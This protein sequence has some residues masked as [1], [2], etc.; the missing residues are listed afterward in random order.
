MIR[1]R[2]PGCYAIPVDA[3]DLWAGLNN[4]RNSLFRALPADWTSVRL[5][6]AAFAPS[7]NYQQAG[8]VVYQDDNNYVQVTRNYN[9][10]NKA[11]FVSEANGSPTATS[12]SQGAASNLYFR[13][14]RDALTERITGYFSVDGVDWVALG[15]AVRTL[16]NPRL[17]IVAGAS[18]GGF[19]NADV[20]WAEIQSTQPVPTLAVTPTSLGFSAVEGSVPA[21]QTLALSNSGVGVMAWTATADPA[22]PAWLT[23]APGSGTGAAAL[24]VAADPTGLAP[25]TYTKAITV[26]APGATNTPRT[27]PVTLTVAAAPTQPTLALSPAVLSFVAVEGSVPAS[28]TLALSNSGVGVMAWTATADAAAPAW[29]A[30][31]P[32]SGTGAAALTVAA[33]PTGLAPGTYTKTIT[34][35]APGATNTPRTVPVTLVVSAA[36]TARFNFN[37]PDRASLLA[38]G[39][40]FLAATPAGGVRDTEQASGAVVSYD[41]AA[42]PGVL[43]IPVD[44]GDLWAGFNNTRNSLFRALPADWTSV[45][46]K[47]AAFAPSA[48]YQQAGLVVYQDDNN[49]VQVTRNYNGGNKAV[50][51]S[52]ANG[53]PTATSVSQGAASNLYFRLDRDALTERITGYFSVDGVNWVA[54]GN[55]VRTLQNPR[56]AIVAGA[57]AGGFPNADVEWAEIQSTQPVPTLAVTPTS[58]G[59]SAVEGSVPAS[60]TLALSNSG[61]G[62]MAWTATADPAAPAWLTVAPGSGTGAAALT[63]AA[64]PTGLAPGTYTKAITV[65]APGATNT[66]RTIPVTLTVAAAPTQPTLALSPAVLSFVAVEGSVPASQTL[67]LSNS[68]VGVMAWTA[69][70]DAA[71]PAW[72]AV[73]PGSGTGAA[74][75]TVAVDP[76][77]LAPGTYTKTITVSAPG[78]TNTPRTVPVTLVVSAAGT[79]RFNFNYPDRAS[80]LAGGWDFLAATPAGGVRD[81]EQASGA[82]VSYDQ[83]AHPGVLRIPVD[84]GDLWAGLNNTRNSLFRALPADWTSVRLKLA[85]FAPSA[86]YQ[87]AGLVVYQDDNNYVQV[88][89]NYNGG[90][91]VVFVSEANGSPTAT[92]VSQG[93]ASNLYFR[94]DRDALTER[95]TGYFSVDG[96]AWVALGNAVRTLQNPRLAIVVGASAGGFP[97]ADVEWAEVVR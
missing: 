54:L 69:T 25:G 71:A 53:S 16:Q 2:T 11:V 49:Y 10:G 96:V 60:Q 43:R 14:D 67:A 59:F 89:R 38:G 78:A 23:V 3:G 9:G 85:A 5:K 31:G 93:A 30:V 91:K 90:N 66:P 24:T 76:T 18:A 4:T 22:A 50:F 83:A 13:L 33:D 72:L 84:A 35:S 47:L 75:L 51:V 64:D 77:G 8:L 81:T 68:G 1:R 80:L 40:D 87:Q 82:V 92:S 95:I 45:R 28:Q 37:Y 36:G 55:A 88:T 94:L 79:A 56:L 26:S 73:S 12:V 58:L 42:H 57:S 15:N 34:V 32:G 17:A 70:A 61:V 21:S 48:N 7:A 19:P 20:E 46:L 62:V 74:A 29:L 65:S 44:A 6:L 52:E 39:W 27:I 41:Q 97:N 86:N 63:V